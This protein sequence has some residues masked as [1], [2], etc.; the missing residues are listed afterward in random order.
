MSSH[1][2][3]KISQHPLFSPR[4]TL[5]QQQ[6]SLAETNT[7]PHSEE[8]QKYRNFLTYNRNDLEL[9]VC[10]LDNKLYVINLKNLKIGEKQVRCQVCH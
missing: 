5:A 3:D 2:A 8:F 10:G 1:L 9:V 6:R 4:G 7:L